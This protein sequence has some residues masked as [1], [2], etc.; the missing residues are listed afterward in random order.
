MTP[1]VLA[2]LFLT[3]AAMS[4]WVQ[5]SFAFVPLHV[6][7][8]QQHRAYVR[9]RE[10]PL[11]RRNLFDFLKQD[12]K[13]EKPTL[14]EEEVVEESS[15]SDDP[16]EKIFSFFFG[17]KEESPMGMKRFGRERFPEQYPAVLDEWAEPVASD[18]SE[19]AAL[20]PLLKNTNLEFRDLKLTYSANRD[21]WNANSFHKKVDKLGGGLVVCTT[22]DGLVCGGYNPKGWV[23][24]GEARGSIAAFL[25]VYK[26]G[27]SELPSKLR[28]VGG[29][30]LA[31]QDLP[32]C[33]PS[34]GADSLVI[35]L[36]ERDPKVARSKLGSYYERFPDGT[37]TL[38][39]KR[40]GSVKLKDLKV[41]H[42]VYGPDE[43]IPFTDAEPF[44]LY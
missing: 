40:G 9:S 31:Q 15:S 3:V 24:Y 44:A 17:A 29:P 25:F 38:F 12:D 35:P 16:V 14:E 10:I 19:M 20:R 30:S 11:S 4:T 26:R 23:G 34:F 13:E 2:T 7:V 27:L 28:K 37:N 22:S 42:G 5:D 32:E 36:D 6:P 43:Y 39:G 41:F 21:G 18:N 33:G 8:A 1:T